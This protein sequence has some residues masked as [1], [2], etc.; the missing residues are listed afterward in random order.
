MRNISSSVGL[1]GVNQRDNVRTVQELLNLVP[2]SD[3]GPMIKL[4][5]DGICGR[6][7]NGAIEKLQAHE[8]GWKRVTTRVDPNSPTWK[9][10][11]TYDKPAKPTALPVPK[12]PEPQKAL[13]TRFMVMMAAKP[14]QQL[15]ANA[16]NFYFQIIDQS[17]QTQKA[18][19]FFGNAKVP[20]PNPT[21]WSIT[22][23]PIV[24]TPQPIGVADW[25]GTAIFYEKSKGGNTT[26]EIY[27]SP[28]VLNGKMIRFGVHAYLDEPSKGPGGVS[29]QFSA[30]FRLREVS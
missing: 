15:N 21:P 8:W 23:P 3:G 9:L 17:D 22:I 16:E 2:H 10:L 11:L 12:P 27:V 6:K 26:T 5:T 14:G 30:P 20:P 4:A 7:T 29:S 13:G 28:D 25:A 18:I 1:R 24:T 19:Y